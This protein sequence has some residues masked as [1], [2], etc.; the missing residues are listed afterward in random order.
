MDIDMNYIVDIL[1]EIA[2]TPSP[3]GNAQKAMDIVEREL[4]RFGFHITK[5]NK[6]ALIASVKGSIDSP[7]RVLSAHVDTLGA[8][9]KEIKGSGRLSITQI[10]GYMGQ[11]VEGANCIIE[12]YDGRE[13]TGTIQTIRPSVHIHKDAGELERDI[14]NYEIVIDEKVFSKEDTIKLGIDVGDFVSFDPKTTVTS[15]GFI[16]S[17]H[18]D[19][20]ASVAILLG[21]AKYIYDSSTV[22]M[23]TLNL[24]ISN[25]E[26]VG[27]GAASSIPAGTIEFVSVD[28]GAPG[29]GQNSSEYAVCICAKDSGGPYDYEFRKRLVALC[30]E[31][32]IDYRVDIYP[33][34]G[35]DAEAALHAGWDLK[36]AL[37]GPGV[38]ASHAYER[39]HKDALL[40]TAKLI[41][42]YIK[43]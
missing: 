36:T 25:Y 3:S 15:S 1:K 35:S 2:E 32:K 20:K 10:G 5:T 17:R 27:H 43:R 18:L 24:Y 38:F 40:N 34:Y 21:V 22:P 19:D 7:Q 41:I 42:E 39:T 11:S 37:I 12:T 33:R 30:I 23:Y 28:M 26:E 13:Y 14:T 8:M 29:E 9:V 31:N 16:K 4:R 6:G